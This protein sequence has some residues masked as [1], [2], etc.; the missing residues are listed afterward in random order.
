[1]ME[2]KTKTFA[3]LNKKFHI[4]FVSVLSV[5]ATSPCLAVLIVFM[6]L[7]NT[8]SKVVQPTWV[9][10]NFSNIDWHSNLLKW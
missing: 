10:T 1:M 7:T 2:G 9:T 8:K 5:L 3:T 4:L 6:M